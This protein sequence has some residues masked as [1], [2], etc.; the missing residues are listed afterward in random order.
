MFMGGNLAHAIAF[1]QG[2]NDHFLLDGGD[3][4]PQVQGTQ[5]LC[6]DGPESILAFR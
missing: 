2:F 6:F 1:L 3:V 4:F 5:H